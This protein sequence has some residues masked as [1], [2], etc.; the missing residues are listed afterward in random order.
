MMK[1][2]NKWADF[3]GKI[4]AGTTVGIIAVASIK[5]TKKYG[6]N[7]SEKILTKERVLNSAFYITEN[8]L[9]NNEDYKKK[10]NKINALLNSKQNTQKGDK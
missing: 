7:I 6:I 9:K 1:K 4:F 5:K 3:T 8:I 2:L 10:F